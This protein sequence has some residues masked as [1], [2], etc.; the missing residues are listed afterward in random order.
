M[1]MPDDFMSTICG[2]AASPTFEKGQAV[3]RMGAPAKH[4][5]FLRSGRVAL[6]RFGPGGEEVTIHVA[7]T[8]DCFA[9]ASLHASRYH[10]TAVALSTCEVAAIPSAELR[11][12]LQSDPNF[13]MQ[14]L[15]LLSTQLRNTRARVERL[16]IKGVAE[17]VRHLLLTEGK[18]AVPAITLRGSVRELAGQLGVTHEALYRVLATMERNG[19]IVRTKSELML[20]R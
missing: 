5:F 14:W 13:A 10:C 2:L 1:G 16:S 15:Q 11:Q 6:R 17:R 3:F 7:N 19:D 20:R 12:R 4:V 9:E 8:G 18:G